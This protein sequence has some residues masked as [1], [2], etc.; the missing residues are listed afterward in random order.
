MFLDPMFL[1]VFVFLRRHAHAVERPLSPSCLPQYIVLGVVAWF[2]VM[3]FIQAGLKQ[4]KTAQVEEVTGAHSARRLPDRRVYSARHQR[5]I[6][7]DLTA[8]LP[9]FHSSSRCPC[10]STA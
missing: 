3:E 9:S 8:W 4:I 2:L 5:S 7:G 1:R 6:P 10:R